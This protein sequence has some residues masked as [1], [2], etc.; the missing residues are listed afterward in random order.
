[1][2]KDD[3]VIRMLIEDKDGRLGKSLRKAFVSCNPNPGRKGCPDSKLIRDLA[4]HRK[5]G[6]PKKFEQVTLHIAECSECAKDALRYVE[7]YK[8]QEKK[9]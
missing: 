4:F 6:G 7:E 2:E 9:K 5:I 3:E 8:K 1:M